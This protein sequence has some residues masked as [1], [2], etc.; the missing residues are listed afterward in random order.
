MPSQPKSKL[1]RVREAVE[2]LKQL[3]EV[4]IH[5]TDPGFLE[6]KSQLDQWIVDGEPRTTKV[7]FPRFG[8]VGHMTLPRLEGRPASYVLKLDDTMKEEMARKERMRMIT[9]SREEDTS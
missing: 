4:G 5:D 7:P 6:T 3:K 2:I 1:E 8:R 9:G